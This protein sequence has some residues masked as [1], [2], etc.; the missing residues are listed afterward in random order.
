MKNCEPARKLDVN[1]KRCGVRRRLDLLLVLRALNLSITHD[2]KALRMLV[3]G[4]TVTSARSA[5]RRVI[6]GRLPVAVL[7]V[8]GS[9]ARSMW[10][11]RSVVVS[12]VIRRSP[13]WV[14][15]A[16]PTFHLVRRWLL[17]LVRRSKA[18]ARNRMTRPCLP[19]PRPIPGRCAGQ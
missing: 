7:A 4:S 14:S 5:S 11:V 3:P 13:M 1:G 18:A 8:A 12:A 9:L 15:S 17:T 16:P 19:R 6:V 2:D 10:S